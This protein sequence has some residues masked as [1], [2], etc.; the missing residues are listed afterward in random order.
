MNLG[1]NISIIAIA[2]I[3]IIEVVVVSIIWYM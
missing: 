3:S 1:K 2:V